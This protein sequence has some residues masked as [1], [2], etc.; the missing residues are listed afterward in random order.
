MRKIAGVFLCLLFLYTAHRAAVT[1]LPQL[2]KPDSVTVY[3]NRIYISDKEKVH[4][5]S[6]PDASFIKSFGKT[7]EGPGEFRVS[8]IDHIGIRIFLH[9]DEIRVNSLGKYITFSLEGALTREQRIPSGYGLQLFK[10]MGKKLVGYHRVVEN[11]E[12]VDHICFY[13]PGTLEK[14]K[15]ISKK[16]HFGQDNA[17]DLLRITVTLRNGTR[18]GP[19]YRVEDN[20]LFVET[21]TA[22]IRVFDG[23]GAPLYTIPP[24]YLEKIKI[25][26]DFKDEVMA[27]LKKRLP[28]AFRNVKKVGFWPEYFPYRNFLAEDGKL[29]VLT[30][31]REK[32][33]N[34]FIILDLKGKPLAKSMVPFAEPEIIKAAPFTIHKGKLY[35]VAD[36]AETEEWELLVH[37]IEG[38]KK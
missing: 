5:Y 32:G 11:K 7:G 35:Q 6:L 14:G 22:D 34:E 33:R 21:E 4:I 19:I 38:P 8:G 2:E 20:K 23:S 1:E 10:P 24:T 3:K 31:K 28:T 9:N 27:Y 16:K 30:Y 15:I 12:R 13:D 37:K 29:Y 36:N 26:P 18:K 25:P 17:V